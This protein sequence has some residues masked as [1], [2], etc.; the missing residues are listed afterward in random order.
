MSLGISR[1]R[2]LSRRIDAV[3]TRIA[4]RRQAI[5]EQQSAVGQGLDQLLGS[6]LTLLLAAA[7]GVLLDRLRRHPA[8]AAV[9]APPA[10]AFAHPMADAA[11]LIQ[12]L[13][14]LLT[15]LQSPPANPTPAAATDDTPAP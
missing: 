1:Q 10:A 5:T 15:S 14:G 13:T 8:A 7:G 11:A 2:R 9:A 4:G 6:P 3:Q 12:A